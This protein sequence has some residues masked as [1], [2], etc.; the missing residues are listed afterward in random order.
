MVVPN[1]QKT[2]YQAL[3]VIRMHDLGS[4]YRTL[5][6]K[7]SEVET[8]S[9]PTKEDA[10]RALGA[11]I[12]STMAETEMG[13]RGISIVMTKS[14]NHFQVQPESWTKEYKSIFALS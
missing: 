8:S 1:S 2:A 9:F 4:F 5:T 11:L 13:E 3:G 10:Y 12:T 7:W 14:G 6:N